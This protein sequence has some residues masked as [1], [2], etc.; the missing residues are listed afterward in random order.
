MGPVERRVFM[1]CS[2]C[3]K[4]KFAEVTRESDTQGKTYVLIECAGC[5]RCVILPEAEA[6]EALG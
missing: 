4:T 6:R 3:G 5:Q 2:R 1:T